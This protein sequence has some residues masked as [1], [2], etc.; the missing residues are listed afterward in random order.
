MPLNLSDE[1]VTPVKI[2]KHLKLSV[3]DILE[4][5]KKEYP[6]ENIT[7]NTKL[8]TEK[9]NKIFKRFEKEQKEKEKAHGKLDELSKATSITF[10]EVTQK[11]EQE[12]EIKKQEE[13]RKKQEEEE[14]KRLK[15]AQRI[16]AE[17]ALQQEIIMKGIE[18]KRREEEAKKQREIDK[19]IEKRKEIIKTEKKRKSEAK[20]NITEKKQRTID[21][22]KIHKGTERV[23]N[24]EP[25]VKQVV[26]KDF[27]VKADKQKPGQTEKKSKFV[28]YTVSADRSQTQ[29]GKKKSPYKKGIEK[30]R[31][32]SAPSHKF[33]KELP[34][35]DDLSKEKFKRPKSSKSPKSK[36]YS[37]K[38]IEDAIRET[39]SKIEEQGK[40][41]SARSLIR[42]KKKK[43]R[44]EKE[45]I[46]QEQ[47]EQTKNILKV[48]EFI[49][50]SDL[51][52][53]M[54]VDVTE[55]I[56]KCFSL[57][58]MVSIN[59]R[60]DK[61][62]IILLADEMGFKVE[63][64]TEYEED[65]L[66]DEPDDPELMVD[67]PPVV[68]VM[69]HV[70][71]G[72]TSLLDNIRKTNVVAGEA[73]GITQHIGA[74][75]VTIN[76]N[77]KITFLD[78]P[79]HEAFTS[80]R[81]RGGQAA[82]IV[83]LVVAADD[84]V[85]PQT[86]EAINHA[87]AANVP[88][89][90]AINKIDKPGASPEK[91]KQQLSERG[92]LVEDW[93]GKYQSVEIS[94][95][96]G[97]NLESL[98]EKILLEAEMQQLKANP[99]S[100]ARGIVLEAK[101]DKGK[102]IV[103]SL[104]VQ[105]GTLNVGDVFICGV[106]SGKIKAMFDEREHKIESAGPSQAV[107]V[108]GFD[109]MPQAG[110]TFIEMDSE[111]NAKEIAIKRQQ[112]KREQDFRQ[113]KFI[114]LDDISMQIKEG[115]QVELNIILK[116]DTDGSAEALA[117]SLLKLSTPEAKVRVIHKAVGQ[118]S[119]S[120]IILAEASNAIIIGFNIR[121]NLNARKLAESKNIDIRLHNIIYN[122]IEEIRNALE[123]LLAPEIQEKVKCTIEVREVFKVPKIGNIA[124]C[125]VQE[126][127]VTRNTKVRLL[128]DGFVIFDGN[129]SSLKRIKDDVREVD[130]G[131]E[132]G[133]GL[134]N[135]ND[136]KIGD[137]IEGYEKLEVKR[138]LT[139]A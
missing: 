55:L 85:M 89:V 79:G 41:S 12:E 130:Q 15:E 97:M 115:K 33:G 68:T 8:D 108:L 105:K 16:E 76:N 60:L 120:D 26:K 17:K 48:T 127:K 104:L 102:G 100:K 56:K 34:R 63:F 9:Q 136:I 124:G 135:Y 111:R 126:G 112:L 114:T 21:R 23:Q 46:Q 31:T 10:K 121:P 123:G 42:K 138:K 62:L 51:A 45:I 40:S 131:Y 106:Y 77:K 35:K 49:S 24:T 30:A 13:E 110:D 73:G 90:V 65:L 95:K 81:A 32:V 52:N 78:T 134:E 117:D 84:S 116:A 98:L 53:L 2:V 54:S 128:R 27:P 66:V 36:E 38:E 139:S 80:M 118:I 72:K 25:R 39:F 99:S 43:E 137:V 29:N 70:D 64:Q 87:L 6:D 47:K 44:L 20:K 22:Q 14:R 93:G 91:I 122:L 58:M 74:Y 11:R 18:D 109:G 3:G 101:L 103:A 4:F 125:Y 94:A 113:I 88:I 133:I 86:V 50:T 96:M 82:D 37:Q 132:C 28:K 59:Q 5:L 19:A 67:R 57:G 61:D 75:T 107:Q 1:K 119:E 69:G 83:V 71:H 92:I 129:I 7:R